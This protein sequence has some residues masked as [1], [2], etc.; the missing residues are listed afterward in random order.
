MIL[1][2]MML[3]VMMLSLLVNDHRKEVMHPAVALCFIKCFL[4]PTLLRICKGRP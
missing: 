4:G 3:G 1:G 2:V